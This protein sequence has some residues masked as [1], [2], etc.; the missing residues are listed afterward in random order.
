MRISKEEG[1]N[2]MILTLAIVL[3]VVIVS[4]LVLWS[5]TKDA[6]LDAYFVLETLT[7]AQNTAASTELAGMAFSYASHELI[8]VLAPIA[9]G[10]SGD[11]YNIN[12]DMVLYFQYQS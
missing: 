10:P 11:T 4:V 12:A 3:L 5:I 6:Y 2:V 7:D 8:P 1:S 9:Q